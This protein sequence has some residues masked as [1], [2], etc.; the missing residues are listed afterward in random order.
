MK[1]KVFD[2]ENAP[3][4]PTS[5]TSPLTIYGETKRDTEQELLGKAVG[6]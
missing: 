2:G 5:P 3:Y 4:L 6:R 1:V